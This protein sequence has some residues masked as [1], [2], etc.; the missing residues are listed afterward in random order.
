[1]T[2]VPPVCHIPPVQPTTQP[3]P[4]N[5]PSIPPA[6]PNVQSLADTVNQMRQLLMYLAGQIAKNAS[7]GTGA[8]S[9]VARWSEASR[10]TSNVRVYNPND[11]TQYVDV[12]QINTL[13]MKDGITGDAWTWH[14]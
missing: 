1:M 9:Q 5:L 6:Q 4:V 11:K 10:T 14:R 8:R 12:E 3:Q 7:N 13:T 2:A